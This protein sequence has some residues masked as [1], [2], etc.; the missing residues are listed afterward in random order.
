MTSSDPND[1]QRDDGRMHLVCT[2]DERYVDPLRGMLSTLLAHNPAHSI[3]LHVLTAG[4]SAE[5]SARLTGWLDRQGV[6]HDLQSVPAERFAAFR[7]HCPHFSIANFFRLLIPEL[8]AGPRRVLYLDADL[9]VRRSLA[10]LFATDMGGHPVAAAIDANPKAE[11]SRLGLEASGGYFNSGVL[12]MDLEVWR[13]DRI[14]EQAIA[15]LVQHH[16]D[17]DRCRYADQDALN[18]VVRGRWRAIDETWNF[19][20]YH[21]ARGFH[22]LT[23]ARR[24]T[25]RQ[26]PALL[27]YASDK[28]PWMRRFRLPFQREFLREARCRGIRYPLDLA[29]ETPLALWR[30]WRAF[31]A[32]RARYRR[33]GIRSKGAP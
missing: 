2:I 26:G 3:A 4:L 33:A 27:H 10:D 21:C 9:L 17:P 8:V 6:A 18:C 32:L 1:A 11:C 12:L 5:A 15:Y 14:A 28:K 29:G 25:L 24:E 16:A 20:V 13:R 30:E 23:P 22:A 19:N 31:R 7:L